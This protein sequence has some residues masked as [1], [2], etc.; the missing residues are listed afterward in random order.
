M[1]IPDPTEPVP[2]YEL[3]ALV[4]KFAEVETRR[5]EDNAELKQLMLDM[6][7]NVRDLISEIKKDYVSN[8]KLELRLKDYEPIR[9]FFWWVAAGVGVMVLATIYNLVINGIK[10]L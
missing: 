1:A 5:K 9:K 2:R 10:T 3:E 6:N 4:S 7:S 8:D